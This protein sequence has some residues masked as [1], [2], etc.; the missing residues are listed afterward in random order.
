MIKKRRILLG[1]VISVSVVAVSLL[2]AARILDP[3]LPDPALADRDGLFRWLLTR[4][5][6]EEPHDVQ[7]TLVRRLETEL[8][9][10]VDWVSTSE[11]LSPQGRD[12]LWRNFETLLKPWFVDK[13][14]RYFALAKEER[15]AYLDYSLQTT[16][17]CR[18]LHQVC[19]AGDQTGDARSGESGLRFVS[20]LLDR[21]D[22][23]KSSAKPAMR[24]RMSR[25]VRDAQ[26]RWMSTH[27]LTGETLQTRRELIGNV[28]EESAE[29]LDW[30]QTVDELNGPGR[31]QF[32]DN[33]VAL[34]EPWFLDKMEGYYALETQQ[35][36]PYLDAMLELVER[37]RGQNA[38]G[39]SPT[40]GSGD[41]E[42]LLQTLLA[43]ISQWKANAD[44]A[45][46]QRINRF[47][48][49][50]FLRKTARQSR[51]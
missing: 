39:R 10:G 33:L 44:A 20:T 43:R 23:W 21:V 38:A 47:L 49:D 34:I 40:A 11:Q 36:T 26:V 4:E 42:A 5:L 29:D 35:R 8:H 14:D 32:R 18:Q 16:T 46:R 9:L 1:S 50:L 41:S 37:Y 17:L 45:Q 13:V 3:P 7:L 24:E 51:S 30:W 15:S 6:A 25:F 48:L 31:E 19:H 22:R 2:A 12:L 27:D 28:D